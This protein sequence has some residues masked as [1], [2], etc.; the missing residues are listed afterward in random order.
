MNPKIFLTIWSFRKELKYVLVAFLAILSL[1][2]IGVVLLTQI[3]TNIIS[4]KLVDQN[5]ITHMIQIK[6]PVTGKVIKEI[7]PI[8]V[9]PAKGRITLEFGQSSLYQPPHTGIDI[10]R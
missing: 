9:W 7:S 5:P 2:V 1:P 10:A 4:D 3:G 6:D 8:V